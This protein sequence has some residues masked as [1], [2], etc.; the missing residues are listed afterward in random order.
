[1]V[2]PYKVLPIH[3]LICLFIFNFFIFLTA[4]REF[5]WLYL[6]LYLYLNSEFMLITSSSQPNT[7]G[8]P[9]LSLFCDLHLLSPVV[10]S[11]VPNVGCVP[12][13]SALRTL[14]RSWRH[15]QHLTYRGS[16]VVVLFMEY[17]SWRLTVKILSSKATWLNYFLRLCYQSN[18]Q[19]YF[20]CLQSILFTFCI[21]FYLIS[22][23]I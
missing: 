11:M 18:T 2:I 7:A 21:H 20:F 23:I 4:F 8:S 9:H 19:A 10:R 1:M 13:C 22:F 12:R 3:C 5:P 14:V 15:H 17:I 6:I 16:L